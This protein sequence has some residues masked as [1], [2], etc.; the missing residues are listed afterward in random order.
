[1]SYE[2]TY[3]NICIHYFIYLCIF[4]IRFKN[5][6]CMCTKICENYYVKKLNPIQ[7]KRMMIFRHDHIR[8]ESD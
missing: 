6:T 8:I 2:A 7:L 3:Q 4:N 1:M 5:L